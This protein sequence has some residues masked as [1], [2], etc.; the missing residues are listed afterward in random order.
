[1]FGAGPISIKGF[2]GTTLS[3]WKSF[4]GEG[5]LEPI[6]DDLWLG[7]GLYFFDG[8]PSYARARAVS[9]IVE[10]QDRPVIISAELTLDNYLDLADLDARKFVKEVFEQMKKLGELDDVKITLWD[11]FLSIFRP[12]SFGCNEIDE[13]VIGK[14][15]SLLE[16]ATH[17]RK[18]IQAIR[19]VYPGGGRLFK[20]SWI[21]SSSTVIVVLRDLNCA[22]L[23]LY[24]EEV[25]QR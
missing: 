21:W 25:H 8:G 3:K 19:W 6:W 18:V 12:F 5:S 22:K 7:E 24:P 11:R 23:R 1:M 15:I 9:Q 20:G 14:S 16:E 4:E 10:G 2:L 13:R 17:E